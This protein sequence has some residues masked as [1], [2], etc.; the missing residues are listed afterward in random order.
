MIPKRPKISIASDSELAIEK[1]MRSGDFG[2]PE[3][4]APLLRCGV[5][6]RH[7]ADTGTYTE[8]LALL[9][10]Q[11]GFIQVKYTFWVLLQM[12]APSSMPRLLRGLCSEP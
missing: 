6:R 7:S 9:H 1:E 2:L 10:A 8:A 5:G 4:K 11:K 3:T 12:E